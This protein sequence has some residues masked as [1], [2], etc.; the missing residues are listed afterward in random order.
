[1]TLIRML[2][3]YMKGCFVSCGAL[4]PVKRSQ[5]HRLSIKQSMALLCCVAMLCGISACGDETP[6]IP[7]TA[8]RVSAISSAQVGSLTV[9]GTKDGK[10]TAV[11]SEGDFGSRKMRINTY[12]P[13]TGWGTAQPLGTGIGDEADAKI[14]VNSSGNAMLVWIRRTDNSRE[15]MAAGFKPAD[16]WGTPI[17]LDATGDSLEPD[18]TLDDSDNATASWN[19]YVYGFNPTVTGMVARF[20][21]GTWSAPQILNSGRTM[22]IWKV[23]GNSSGNLMAIWNQSTPQPEL[24]GHNY[25]TW[26]SQFDAIAGWLTPEAVGNDIFELD[27]IG[28]YNP[29][30]LPGHYL[31]T[32]TVDQQG[33]ALAFWLQ[34]AGAG[35][36]Y[37]ITVNHFENGSGWWTPEVIGATPSDMNTGFL[38]DYSSITLGG[39]G[40]GYF[41][42]TVTDM[43]SSMPQTDLFAATYKTA[44]GWT[45]EKVLAASPFYCLKPAVYEGKNTNLHVFWLQVDANDV[46]HLFSKSR[47]SAGGWGTAMRLS[48]ISGGIGDY[49]AIRDDAGNVTVIWTQYASGKGMVWAKVIN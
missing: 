35:G 29:Q 15:I 40:G 13:G 31:P 24:S 30:S 38:S 8:V 17:V 18:V 34:V 6:I 26:V 43:L 1:M 19:F 12:V 45:T 49:K 2:M 16:G 46:A 44:T 47:L 25:N 27:G 48:S 32:L 14:A 42:W 37:G 23:S 28:Y 11:W 21:S 36:S 39:A 3:N 33:N 7:D 22:T 5:P 41:S 10:I 9:S 4:L 20:S